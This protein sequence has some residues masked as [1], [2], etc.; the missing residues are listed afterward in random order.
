[1]YFHICRIKCE[2]SHYY[3]SIHQLYL[4]LPV[5]SIYNQSWLFPCCFNIA[6]MAHNVTNNM[7]LVL[8]IHVVQQLWSMQIYSATFRYPQ[9]HAHATLKGPSQYFDNTALVTTDI[10]TSQL[11][12]YKDQYLAIMS[13]ILMWI[14][15]GF[16]LN[17]QIITRVGGSPTS[18]V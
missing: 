10:Q 11:S 6:L 4:W 15:G 1:M 12:N 18:P 5:I 13:T 3:V 16:G 9:L 2:S 7:C 17:F 8:E 14:T